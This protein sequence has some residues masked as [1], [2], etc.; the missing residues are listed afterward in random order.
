MEGFLSKTGY[1]VIHTSHHI[2]TNWR[3]NQVLNDLNTIQ[4][5]LTMAIGLENSILA[6]CNLDSHHCRKSTILCNLMAPATSVDAERLFSFSGGTVS[7]LR[8]QLSKD[9]AHAVVMV[10]QWAGDPDLIAV[11]EFETQLA[12]GWSWKKKRKADIPP[13]GQAALKAIVVADN[14]E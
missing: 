9:S 3:C 13:D 8:N 6:S 7:K 11:E 12:E 2:Q 10:G 1:N 14:I 5:F 4:G